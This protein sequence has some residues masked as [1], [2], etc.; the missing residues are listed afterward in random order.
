MLVFDFWKG[1]R[2]KGCTFLDYLLGFAFRLSVRGVLVFDVSTAGFERG[3]GGCGRTSRR[4]WIP[5]EFWA[6]WW[7]CVSSD[8]DL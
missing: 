3:C 2:E 8:D 6:D 1:R 4:V 7:P 5:L